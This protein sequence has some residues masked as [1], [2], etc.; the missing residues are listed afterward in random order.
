MS[1]PLSSNVN[2]ASHPKL[3]LDHLERSVVPVAHEVSD[4][5]SGIRD[6][7][8]SLSV[9]NPCSLNNSFVRTHVINEFNIAHFY[10]KK[11]PPS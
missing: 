6:A 10:F 5:S 2:W 9:R 7:S 8:S 4:E 1:Y 3:E 11:S